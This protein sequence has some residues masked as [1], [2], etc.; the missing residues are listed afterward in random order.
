[1]RYVNP[2]GVGIDRYI[3]PSRIATQ[4]K[5]VGEVIAAPG[6]VGRIRV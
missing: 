5:F 3:V 2:S 6:L 1:V 4:R